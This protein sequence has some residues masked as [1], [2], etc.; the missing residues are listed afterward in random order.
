MSWWYSPKVS[1]ERMQ[2]DMDEELDFIFT[3]PGCEFRLGDCHYRGCRNFVC[4]VRCAGR[5]RGALRVSCGLSCLFCRL[6]AQVP[7][8]GGQ[9]LSNLIVR[10]NRLV[11]QRRSMVENAF[12]NIKKWRLFKCQRSQGNRYSPNRLSLF[13]LMACNA[14][15][16]ERRWGYIGAP[17]AFPE[18]MSDSEAD[19]ADL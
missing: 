18:N 17:A 14:H 1:D 19:E 13:F 5:R 8:S 12:A 15:N 2:S 9:P 6:F 10:Y 4:K 11:S 7:R 3:G 16:M